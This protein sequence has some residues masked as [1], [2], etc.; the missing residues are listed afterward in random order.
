MTTP[1]DALVDKF[2]E[3]KKF[4]G[5]LASPDTE[6][7][8]RRVHYPMRVTMA[9]SYS[10]PPAPPRPE[11]ERP[12]EVPEALRQ[13]E[14]KPDPRLPSW[15]SDPRIVE[16]NK[17]IS[18]AEGL[19]KSLDKQLREAEQTLA[20][21]ESQLYIIRHPS[22]GEPAA[23]ASELVAATQAA[24]AARTKLEGIQE[25]QVNN[26][27][28]LQALYAG[29]MALETE[30][31]PKVRD[32]LARLKKAK[33]AGLIKAVKELIRLNGE[34]RSLDLQ[35]EAEFP[36]LEVRPGPGHFQMPTRGGLRSF[37]W[38]VGRHL[39]EQN[40]REWVEWVEGGD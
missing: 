21:A 36:G 32:E 24:A 28:G 26:G 18:D 4:A 3:L 5:S 38:S 37:S 22:A 20:V 11:T 25:R 19:H 35:C 12:R 16:M 14:F 30:V 40:F 17:Q 8:D 9:P 6:A 33:R 15:R 1:A 29:R 10:P 34:M 39:T 7:P 27:E 13:A 31:K 2:Q 23:S